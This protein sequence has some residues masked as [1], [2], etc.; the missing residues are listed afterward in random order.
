MDNYM[1]VL[2]ST[3]ITMNTV[4]KLKLLKTITNLNLL[5]RKPDD[6]IPD[7]KNYNYLLTYNYSVK[8]LTKLYKHYNLKKYY[9]DNTL[10]K[11]SYNKNLLIFNLYIYLYQSSILIKIQKIMRGYLIRKMLN[12]HGPATF[13][14]NRCVNK[15][16]FFTLEDM[17]DIPINQFFSYT[18]ENNF[19]YGFNIISF[20]NLIYKTQGTLKNPYTLNVIS[21]SIVKDYRNM[22]KMSKMLKIS[23]QTDI[24]VLTNISNQKQIQFKALD[25][26][27]II[28]GLGNYAD[29]QW[30]LSLNKNNLIKM[31]R[32]LLDIWAYRANLSLELKREIC[33]P[34]GNPFEQPIPN[35][36]VDYIDI[37]LYTLNIYEKMVTTGINNDSKSL[38]AYYILGA[39]TLVNNN[40]ATAMPWLYESMRY[41]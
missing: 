22:L 30:L 28:N 32:L 2:N 17:S 37:Q 9:Y 14:R 40:A 19:T 10:K 13:D 29:P 21:N 6:K 35:M 12:S 34:N 1:C 38:G 26:F 18:D 36:D 4:T 24:E 39:L 27:Q 16:D 31:L 25:I 7:F 33:P 23:F 41:I 5:K 11:H 20:H 15:E 8:E 3:N